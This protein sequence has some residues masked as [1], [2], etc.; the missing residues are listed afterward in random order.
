MIERT[1][2]PA[3]RLRAGAQAQTQP[4]PARTWIHDRAPRLRGLVRER[5]RREQAWAWLSLV[6]LIVCWDAASRIGEHV[7]PPRPRLAHAVEEDEM[8][9]ADA[10]FSVDL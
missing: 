4:E 7:S 3:R 10:S 5:H 9:R 6:A 1:S 8:F 2:V